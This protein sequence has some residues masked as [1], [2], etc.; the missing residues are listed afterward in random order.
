MYKFLNLFESILESAQF[1]EEFKTSEKVQVYQKK[2][3]FASTRMTQNHQVMTMF[4][5]FILTTTTNLF[6]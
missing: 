2:A 1:W 6:N 5:P 4:H 3:W